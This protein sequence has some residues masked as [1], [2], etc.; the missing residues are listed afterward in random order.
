MVEEEEHP[1]ETEDITLVEGERVEFEG[2]PEEVEEDITEEELEE[3]PTPD[4]CEMVY[5][6]ITTGPIYLLTGQDV[7]L[8]PRRIEKQGNRLAILFEKYNIRIKHLSLVFFA[9]GW[10][11]D[12]R[13]LYDQAKEK[14]GKGEGLREKVGK[15]IGRGSKSG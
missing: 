6:A 15:A 4:E 11:M 12:M 9:L 10:G 2:K 13:Y 8:P 7:E 5:E 1:E 3:F 14:K